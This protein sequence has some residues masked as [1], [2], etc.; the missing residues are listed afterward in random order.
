M[1]HVYTG[2]IESGVLK[3]RNRKSFEED[4]KRMKFKEVMI[5]LE[6]KKTQRSSLQNRYYWGCMVPIVQQGLT[7]VGYEVGLDDTHQF[8]KANFCFDEIAN[9]QTGEV[10][11]LTKST[12]ELTTTGFMEFKDKVQRWAA[13][14]LNVNIPD[15]N[16]QTQIFNA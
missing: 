2:Y 13:E 3:I 14:F 4:I 1:K 12:T 5:T 10:F 9:E 8:L 6:K 15:P 7:N 11:R 16:E